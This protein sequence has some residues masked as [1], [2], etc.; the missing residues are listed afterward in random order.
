VEN[1]APHGRAPPPSS[2][3]GEMGSNLRLIR[4]FSGPAPHAT[5][6]FNC[7]SR[8]RVRE[9]TAEAPK[10]QWARGGAARHQSRVRLRRG[11]GG[12]SAAV[13]RRGRLLGTQTTL[14][15]PEASRV[16]C[17]GA[18]RAGGGAPRI[19]SSQASRNPA[20]W[21]EPILLRDG[22]RRGVAGECERPCATTRRHSQSVSAQGRAQRREYG[23]NRW[24]RAGARAAAR[25]GRRGWGSGGPRTGRAC[26]AVLLVASALVK[27]HLAAL[28][29]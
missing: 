24:C 2:S 25:N 13:R 14:L 26:L 5:Y 4:C 1:P 18:A 20:A 11:G 28:G 8:G 19:L 10:G 29:R 27:R 15:C 12:V 6:G 22:K 9:S 21:S 7:D 23:G 17:V 3:S 16:A